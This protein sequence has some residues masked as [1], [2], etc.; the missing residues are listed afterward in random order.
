MST[1][2]DIEQQILGLPPAERARLLLRAW[3]SLA[4]D[5]DVAADPAID[6]Q[7]LKIAIERDA[8]LTNGSTK[9]IEDAEFR[10]RTGADG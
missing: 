4:D 7:G 8:E 2:A 10:R 9:A 6:P 1:T 5:A 3:E